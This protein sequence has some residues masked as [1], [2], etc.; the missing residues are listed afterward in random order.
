[1]RLLV[2]LMMGAGV[3]CGVFVS[4]GCSSGRSVVRNEIAAPYRSVRAIEASL[5]VGVSYLEY[6]NLV[7]AL[8]R[9][10][11]LSNDL[12][13]FDPTC[14][15]DSRRILKTYSDILAMYKDA[16]EVWHAELKKDDYGQSLA[17]IA[18]KYNMQGALFERTVHFEQIRQAIWERAGSTHEKL[19]PSVYGAPL[20]STP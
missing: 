9:E 13:L 11:L 10:V 3:T 20:P 7:S 2:G 12:V 8:S 5:M 18:R 16:G 4:S 6:S 17:D 19:L 15:R 1:M 14:G